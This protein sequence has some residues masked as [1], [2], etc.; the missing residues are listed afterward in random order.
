MIGN[1]RKARFLLLVAISILA[2][3][4]GVAMVQHA[5]SF[6][7][8]EDSP[9][10]EIL[11]YR[12]GGSKQPGARPYPGRKAA[13]RTNIIGSM[14]RADELY[15]KWRVLSTD[16]EYEETVDLRKRLPADIKDHRIHFA[17]KGPQLYVYLI[18]PEPNPRG[19]P[20]YVRPY[21][22]KKTLVI[23]PG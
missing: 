18:T 12:Y 1:I 14:L 13:Q 4:C 22:H 23:F 10:I 7:V 5:F 15:V 20:V 3:A 17:V 8:A 11:D 19:G 9:G 2:S 21:G 16:R 6:D